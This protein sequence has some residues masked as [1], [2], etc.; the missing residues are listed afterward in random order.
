[1]TTLAL[2]LT[3]TPILIGVASPAGRRWGPAISGWLIGLPLTS[4]PII[5]LL[6][7]AHGA[8]FG[9][10]TAIGTLAGT[11]SECA[12]CLA[13]GWLAW[14][15]AG[16]WAAVAGCLAFLAGAA[17]LQDVTLA[18]A[19]LCAVIVVALLASLW[20]MPS[21]RRIEHGDRSVH[22]GGGAMRLAAPLPWWDLPARMILAT[23]FVVL[24]TGIAPT[25]GPHLTGLLAPFPVYAVILTV[26]AQRQQGRAAAVGVLRGLLLGLF[27]FAAFFV[28]LAL[29]LERASLAV[30]FTAAVVSAL[31][32]QGCSL[33]LMQRRV[34]ISP[35]IAAN[36]TPTA[37]TH[38]R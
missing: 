27:S 6:A 7:L 18:L 34:A 16:L 1:M 24:L 12:F 23:A 13:Y 30:A 3:L 10:A 22:S 28:T 5:F 15:G 31:A 35:S 29:L 11:L 36:E 2:K 25:L 17:A 38:S 37:P 8:S 14:R 19:P 4:G 33:W 21:Q 26:F 20:L 9:A 32:A